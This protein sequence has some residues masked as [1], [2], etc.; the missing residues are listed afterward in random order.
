M[1][2]TIKLSFLT[3]C[4]VLMVS[5]LFAQDSTYVKI[6]NDF[7]SPLEVKYPWIVSVLAVLAVLSEVIAYIPSVKA[8]SVVQLI[9][10]WVKALAPKKP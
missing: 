1:K 10:N 7:L 9:V 4:A 8:N 3:L 5:T 2:K 6:A